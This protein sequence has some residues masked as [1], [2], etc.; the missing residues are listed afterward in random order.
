M[1]ATLRDDIRFLGEVLGRVLAEQEGD[2]FLAVVERIRVLSREVRASGDSSRRT[3]L[4]G[5]VRSLPLER[6]ALV[7]R[8]FGLYFH[9]ANIAEQHHRQRRH[10]DYQ[11]EGQAP[12]RSLAEA[13][14]MITRAGVSRQAV[15]AAASRLRLELVFTAHPT[16]ATRRGILALH[17][18]VARLLERRDQG[19]DVQEA[20]AEVLTI[21]WQTDEVRAQRPRVVD[22]I[23]HCLFFFEES[24]LDAAEHVMASYRRRLPCAPTPLRFGT[25]VGGD[26]DG[27]PGAGPETMERAL[28]RAREMLLARY[29][30]EVRRLAG[31]LSMSRRLVPASSELLASLA[32]D[33]QALADRP[34]G[35]DAVFSEEPYRR[36][37]MFISEKLEN[38][39]RDTGGPAYTSPPDLQAD[40]DLIDRSLRE[41]RGARVADGRLAALRRR[42]EIFGF[43]LAR[44]DIRFHVEEVREPSARLREAL[45][46]RER[47]LARHGPEALG[48]LIVSGTSS[49]EEI[50]RVLDLAGDTVPVA[51]LFETIADLRAAPRIVE[52]LLVDRRIAPGGKLEVMLGHSD[53]GKDGGYLTAQWEIYEAQEAL[54]ELAARHGIE[55]MIFHGRGGSTARGGGPTYEAI[56]AQPPGHPPGRLK[57]TEQGETIA[58]KYSL[59]G[60]AEHNL[61]AA[62]A[63]TLLSAFPEV[64]RARPPEGAR[65]RLASTAERA[66]AAYRALVDDPGFVPFFRAFTPIDE[67][68]LLNLGSRPTRYPGRAG[69]LRSLRAI[70]WVFAWTQTRCLL[71]VWYGCGTAFASADL[72]DLRRLYREWAFFRS[73]VDNLEMT[74]A[75]SCLEIARGY[76]AL[77]D[78]ERLFRPI[79][80]EHERTVETVLAIVEAKTL[81]DRQPVLQRSIRLR[82]PY[83]DPMSAIQVELLRRHR[84]TGDPEVESA[85]VRSIVAIAAAMRNTG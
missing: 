7:L 64:T 14:Q 61:E 75:K 59:M 45:R 24:L 74:L 43:H 65:E 60:L 55:I 50:R 15:K 84:A 41:H 58:F 26:M 5:V 79:A 27:N 29:R 32:A 12:R 69:Y 48:P 33:G 85:L 18:D 70:P 35:H 6:Q 30:D 42:V 22:E 83:V 19:H 52:E 54:V 53:A 37:L 21:L 47:L 78:D 66:Y 25:W 40:L 46:C 82:N 17:R 36:K 72:D 2:E 34:S 3:E 38:T 20:L 1:D 81:L 31:A 39:L 13:F 56:L 28:E 68:A 10:R 76:L 73:V 4:E 23:R 71:P 57:L 8:A 63:A 44:L 62:V 67:L 77:V 49:A 9:L 51:P 11:R 80:E 16:E